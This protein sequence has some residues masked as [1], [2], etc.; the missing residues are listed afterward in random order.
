MA[1]GPIHPYSAVPVGQGAFPFLYVGSGPG[2][3]YEEMLG[4]QGGTSDVTWSL[5]FR[6]PP[7][8]P[9][10]GT[11]AYLDLLCMSVGTTGV[12]KI[13]P[14]WTCAGSFQDPSSF[15]LGAEGAQT[16]TFTG[17]SYHR[18]IQTKL[19]LDAS[20]LQANQS[21]VMD[22]VFESTGWTLGPAVGVVPSIIW[23]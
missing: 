9:S 18:Y 4:V 23:E 17:S 14:K 19:L 22:I 15:T 6:M 13:N 16:V 12:A 7:A 3:R 5:R 2:S 11:S 20:S 1:Y 8:L 10:D 21:L